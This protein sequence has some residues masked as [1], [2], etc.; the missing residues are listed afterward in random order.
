MNV[1]PQLDLGLRRADLVA[2]VPLFDALDSRSQKNIADILNPR[3][4]I[5]G[6]IVVKSGD[7]GR[8][9]Y[10]VS[11]G[12]L[13]VEINDT[14]VILGSGDF[15][16]ELALLRDVPR[17]ADVVAEGFCDLLTLTRNDLQRLLSANPTLRKTIESTAAERIISEGA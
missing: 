14:L 15:F 13:R 12:A 3:L 10:F 7:T 17:N 4:A 8:E 1:P 9:M 11:S 16:G 6:E 5:P 2:R